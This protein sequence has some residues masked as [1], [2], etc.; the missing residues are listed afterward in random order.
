MSMQYRN[1]ENT[2]IAET[3]VDGS[4]VII[5]PG[6]PNWPGS[7]AFNVAPYIPEPGPTEADLLSLERDQMVASAFQV[8]AALLSAGLLDTV[9]N[10]IA[11]ADPVTKLAWAHA[12]EYHRRSPTIAAMSAV[13]GMT[14]AEIDALYRIAMTIK[15]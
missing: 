11:L 9:E 7:N 14:D 1:A 10:A 3:R 4:V 12:I 15:A 2:V 5:E 13:I 8:R 6:M